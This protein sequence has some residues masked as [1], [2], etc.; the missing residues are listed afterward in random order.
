MGAWSFQLFYQGSRNKLRFK[1]FVEPLPK[2][3]LMKWPCQL[4]WLPWGLPKYFNIKKVA[5]STVFW[6]FS[7]QPRWINRFW[8]VSYGII[9]DVNRFPILLKA[10]RNVAV[11]ESIFGPYVELIKHMDR[12]RG[13]GETSYAGLHCPLTRAFL[14]WTHQPPLE[15]PRCSDLESYQ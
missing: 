1:D 11:P 13:D 8:L 4:I 3:I 2:E 5:W 9:Y 6:C 14:N 12:N 7:L 10:T 15:I